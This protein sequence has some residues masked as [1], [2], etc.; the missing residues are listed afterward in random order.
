MD[1]VATYMNAVTAKYPS[2]AFIPM[3]LDNDRQAIFVA[4]GSAFMTQPETARIAR[5]ANTKS[6]EHF[7]ASE[8]L[9]PELLDSGRCEILADPEPISFDADGM[10]VEPA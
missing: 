3:V 10:L 4:L 1:P 6:V 7:W 9:L 8:P 5:I 2:G